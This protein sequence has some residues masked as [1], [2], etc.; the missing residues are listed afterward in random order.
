MKTQPSG[1]HEAADAL[2]TFPTPTRKDGPS[3]RFYEID[4]QRLP[5]VTHVLSCIGK[6]ALIAW[7][8]NQ[9]RTLCIDVA[10]DL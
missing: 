1:F 8:A 4:G 6:P 3:G 7:A 2:A 10:A 9:E 5:S